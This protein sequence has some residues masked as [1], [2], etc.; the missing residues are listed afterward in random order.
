MAQQ[1]LIDWIKKEEANGHSQK[2][3]YDVL[4]K[5]GH[6]QHAIDEAFRLAHQ[7]QMKKGIN[8]LM[9]IPIV[10]LVLVIGG[11]IV[12]LVMFY[13]G[14]DEEPKT[15]YTNTGSK[16]KTDVEDNAPTELLQN[17]TVCDACDVC[18]TGKLTPLRDVSTNLTT[19]VQCAFDKHCMEG[20]SCVNYRCIIAQ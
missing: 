9:T 4:L 15:E 18:K 20:Y 16:V 7:Q 12:G 3:L 19:C 11:L 10:F 8:W 5:A 6:D 14:P 17:P 13:S 1:E 2:S